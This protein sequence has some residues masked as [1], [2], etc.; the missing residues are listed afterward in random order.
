LLKIGTEYDMPFFREQAI[1]R[2]SQQYPTQL[3]DVDAVRNMADF[4]DVPPK[5]H[6]ELAALAFEHGVLSIIPALFFG[7]TTIAIPNILLGVGT[8]NE[9]TLHLSPAQVAKFILA[10]QRLIAEQ[11]KGVFRCFNNGDCPAPMSCQSKKN[12]V[13]NYLFSYPTSCPAFVSTWDEALGDQLNRMCSNCT[14]YAK[15]QYHEIRR[16][17]WEDTP[18]WLGLPNWDALRTELCGMISL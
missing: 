10:S 14:R 12:D 1:R 9:N 13:S 3:H 8:G 17:M 7:S 16:S 15:A 4:V 11:G 5:D 18:R 6:P 2:L